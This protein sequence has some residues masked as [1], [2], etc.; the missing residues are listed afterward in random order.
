MLVAT[1]L[2]PLAPGWLLLTPFAPTAP[3]PTTVIFI[4]IIFGK[5]DSKNDTK[6]RQILK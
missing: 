2:P 4:V 5:C 1:P 6:I 3:A